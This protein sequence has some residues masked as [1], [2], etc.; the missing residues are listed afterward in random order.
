MAQS[1]KCLLQRHEDLSSDP[2]THVQT[3]HSTHLEPPPQAEG[4]RDRQIPGHHWL[5]SIDES[6]RFRFNK[7]LS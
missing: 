5:S 2:S 3:M 7:R 4:N 1:M 6:V